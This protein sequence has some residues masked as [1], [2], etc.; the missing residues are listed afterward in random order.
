MPQVQQELKIF[1][2]DRL[3]MVVQKGKK[4]KYAREL[5]K[6]K[7]MRALNNML[8]KSDVENALL[9][10]GAKDSEPVDE[11]VADAMLDKLEEE[12]SGKDMALMNK[13]VEGGTKASPKRHAV[14]RK[15][16]GKARHAAHK[17]RVSGILKL[18]KRLSKKVR[19]RH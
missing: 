1:L 17:S 4:D 16:A 11:N 13:L 18:E 5:E 19:R 10:S 7:E 14:E 8:T 15:A 3:F 9:S 12:K 2:D 6:I